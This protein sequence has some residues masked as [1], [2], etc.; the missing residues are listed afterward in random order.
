MCF[1]P[2]MSNPVQYQQS[3][4]PAYA[5]GQSGARNTGRRGTILSRASGSSS[6]MSGAG[7]GMDATSVAPKRTVLGA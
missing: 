3:R 7:G 4:E 6:G 5:E 1:S 2:K